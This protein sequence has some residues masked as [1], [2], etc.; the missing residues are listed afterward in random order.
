MTFLLCTTAAVIAMTS[1]GHAADAAKIE[2]YAI[3]T[4]TMTDQ[5]YLTAGKGGMPDE[6]SWV[7]WIYAAALLVTDRF[8]GGVAYDYRCSDSDPCR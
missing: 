3:Q 2:L 6:A 1:I 4:V 5:E 7:R 8:S